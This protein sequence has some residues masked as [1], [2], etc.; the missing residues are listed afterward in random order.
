VATCAPS[1]VAGNNAGAWQTG[2]DTLTIRRSSTET[3]TA[4]ASKIQLFLN[5]LKRTNQSIF[6]SATAPGTIN[7][8][9]EVRDLI[10]R[11][12][13]VATNSTTQT[14]LPSLWRKTLGTASGAPAMLD[15]EI[16]PGVEDFQVEFGID[17][18]DHDSTAGIDAAQDKVPPIGV[19]DYFTGVV[20]R[21]VAP[22]SPLLSLAVDGRQSQVV[23]V[24]VWLRVRADRPEVGYSDDRT[25]NYA[26]SGNFNIA[27]GLRGFRRV[28]MTRTIYLR[29]VR[30]Q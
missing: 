7:V 8:D 23:A 24:R 3:T 22:N 20:S 1:T 4:T 28:L 30:F 21:W 27:A 16:L 25:Y 26:G 15:E 10:V 5:R 2:T 19:P 13:Y 12:Y 29:N 17:T 9:R 18:A 11:T 14:G 6:N